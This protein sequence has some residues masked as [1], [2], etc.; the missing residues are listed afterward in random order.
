ML[1][2]AAHA[3]LQPPYAKLQPQ[4]PPSQASLPHSTWVRLKVVTC[5]RCASV[6]V[7]SRCTLFLS[8]N[9]LLGPIALGGGGAG[10]RRAQGASRKQCTGSLERQPGLRDVQ[11]P[12]PVCACPVWE[13]P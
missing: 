9:E 7:A 6:S 11:G 4:R 8:L 3:K 12:N 2:M 1:R 5:G 13:V 10:G